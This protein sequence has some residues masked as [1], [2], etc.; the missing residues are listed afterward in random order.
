M[1]KTIDIVLFV[2]SLSHFHSMRPDISF[3]QFTYDAVCKCKYRRP[4]V[5]IFFSRA[6]LQWHHRTFDFFWCF[7][8]DLNSI[9]LFFLREINQMWSLYECDPISLMSHLHLNLDFV[10]EKKTRSLNA[11]SQINPCGHLFRNSKQSPKAKQEI[12]MKH[13]A[14]WYS[15]Q[16][17]ADFMAFNRRIY[18]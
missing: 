5:C 7:D 3:V 10:L 11:T 15:F 8:T 9:F 13:G 18:S 2:R 6:I 16:T 4:F 1:W 14:D 12:E 17:R